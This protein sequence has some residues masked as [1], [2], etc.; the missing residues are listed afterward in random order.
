MTNLRLKSYDGIKPSPPSPILS[1]RTCGR[2]GYVNKLESKYCEKVGC[3]YPLTYEAFEDIKT[4]EQAKFQELVDKSN[5]ERDN[6]IQA[7]QQEL[8]SKTQEMQSLSELCKHSLEL[9]SKQNGTISDYKGMV[10]DVNSR[11]HEL[12]GLYENLKSKFDTSVSITKTAF[13]RIDELQSVMRGGD[14][15]IRPD[16]RTAEELQRRA[17]ILLQVA[18][19][20]Q[21]RT[22]PVNARLTPE[23][24][25]KVMAL[26]NQSKVS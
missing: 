22:A 13:E 21:K 6:T 5:L 16:R 24:E 26:I 17:K 20:W 15:L 19:D 3:N 10:D 1:N 23:E 2:C 11:Y 4:A 8:K 9:S 7:L 25:Q 14:V 12:M 18:P